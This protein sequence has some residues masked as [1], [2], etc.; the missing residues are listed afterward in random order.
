MNL[1]CQPVIPQYFTLKMTTGDDTG[2]LKALERICVVIPAL[3]PFLPMGKH[4]R[5]TANE[6]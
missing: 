2:F 4:L 1:E 3:Y 6:D 5:H